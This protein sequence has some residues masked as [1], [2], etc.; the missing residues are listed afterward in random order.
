MLTNL[1]CG[2]AVSCVDTIIALSLAL[3]TAVRQIK[4]LADCG[5]RTKVS[6]LTQ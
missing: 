1:L 3:R 2:I 5:V 6:N 4:S